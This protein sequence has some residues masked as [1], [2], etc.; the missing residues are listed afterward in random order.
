[1]IV[2]GALA[3]AFV[4]VLAVAVI[5]DERRY[6]PRTPPDPGGHVRI[7]RR[8]YDQDNDDPEVATDGN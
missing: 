8:P 3:V 1:M 5:A 2:L 4:L 7:V 6:P